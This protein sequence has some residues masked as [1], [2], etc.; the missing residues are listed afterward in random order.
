MSEEAYQSRKERKKAEKTNQYKQR[1]IGILK[2]GSLFKRMFIVCLVLGLVLIGAGAITF[3]SMIKGT[4]TLD[5]SKLLDPLST[6]FYDKD[7]NF[8]Y[9]YGKEKRTKITYNQVPKVLEHAFIATEDSNFYEHFGIDLKRTAKA[10]FVNV[11][12]DFGSQGGSTITQ[13][14]I[15]NYFLSP[16]K[17]LKRKVQEWDLSYQLEKKYSKQDILMMYLNKIYLGN[18]SYGVA[19]AAKN[20]Y[21][22]ESDDLK[23]MTLAQA[24]MIAGLTQ[25]PNNYDPTIP[26]NKEA[27]TKRRHIVLSS[28]LRDGYITE[29]Q[30]KE[31]EKVPVTEGLVAKNTQ[32]S[33]PYEAFLDAAVKE[34]KGKL[35]DV[36]ISEDGLSIYTT[37]DPKAQDFADKMMNTSEIIAYPDAKFQGAFVLLDT[38]TGEVRAIGSGRNDYKAQ[39]SGHNFAVDIKRQPGSIFKPIFDYGPAIEN[40][41][42]STAHLINDQKT[43]YSTGQPISNWDHQHHGMVTMRTALQNSYNIP[44]LLTLR[45]VGMDKAKSF[46]EQLGITFKSNQVYESYSIGSNTV[47]P[48]DMAGGYSAF[49]NN[50]LYNKPHFVQ[51]VV[52]ADGAVVNFAGKS[53]RVMQDYTAYMVTDML[54]TVVNAGTGTTANVPGLDVAGKTGTT[55]FDEKTRAKYGYPSSATNDSWFAG[56]TPQYTMAVWTG[57]AQNGQDNYMSGNTTKIS[58]LMFKAMMEAFGTDTANFQQPESVYRVNNELYIKGIDSA[59]VPPKND[60]LIIH[61]NKDGNKEEEKHKKE[62]KELKKEEKELKKEEEKRRKKEEKKKQKHG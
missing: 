56:Y 61:P 10:I 22:I 59:E 20:Y 23:K 49:G 57:Y 11:T 47:S 3:A 60:N 51:K 1:S 18:R 12:G 58:Q 42:W 27:A 4:P 30:M 32:Q 5:S 44:A 38:K 13:Q 37:L 25:S 17:T 55:N 7:G 54:R 19:A 46:A 21:G 50:G 53:K 2:K 29:K 6:K 62:E 26:E 52:F 39:F 16:E 43:T 14:V 15:K 34:V 31:A 33:M 8:L 48:L 41:K 9:E 36:D 24:A 35:K 45:E 28:M 40:L